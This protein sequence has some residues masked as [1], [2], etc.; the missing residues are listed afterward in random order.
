[1]LSAPLDR[2]LRNSLTEIPEII[3]SGFSVRE[4]LTGSGVTIFKGRTYFGSWRVTAGTLVW[5]SS[6]LGEANYLA[7]TV[8]EAARHTMLLILRNLQ[9]SAVR[10]Y[11]PQSLSA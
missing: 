2:Q 4:G 11:A 6:N 10:R 1:M 5:V 3:A 7:D 8:D 9:A